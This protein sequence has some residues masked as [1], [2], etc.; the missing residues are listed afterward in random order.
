VTE[1]A[2]KI[3]ASKASAKEKE[4]W[5]STETETAIESTSVVETTSARKSEYKAT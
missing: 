2:G 5:T 4:I 3:A 1:E